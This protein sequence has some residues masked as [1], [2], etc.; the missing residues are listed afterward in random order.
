MDANPG[1]GGFLALFG[2][3]L[4][5]GLLVSLAGITLVTL[6]AALAAAV[7]HLRR[8]AA[9]DDSR[10]ALFWS[11][12]RRA[13][14]PGLL[15]GGAALVLVG[16]LLLDIDL[17]R[18]GFLPGAVLVEAVGWIGLAAVAVALFIS[19]AAWTPE[20]G[21]LPAV[22]NIPRHVGKDIPGALYLAATAGFVIIVTWALPP[23][24]VPAL[25][26]A[27]LAIVAIPG[28]PRGR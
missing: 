9:A 14:V 21:W 11:D 1:A 4:L 27:V 23:L 7:R 16:I 13:V 5:V 3:V 2:E 19:V 28:R 17:A 18:S 8:F 15:V 6:P 10:L 12:F 26:C 25:G 24:L 22:R 20:H